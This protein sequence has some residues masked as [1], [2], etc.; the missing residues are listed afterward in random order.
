MSSLP[1]PTL[2]CRLSI[3][4]LFTAI[5]SSTVAAHAADHNE[6]INSIKMKLVLVKAGEFNMG[7]SESDDA[8]NKAFPATVKETF[9][10]ERPRHKVRITKDFYMGAS[11]V[12]L[13]QFREFINDT[14]YKTEAEKDDKGGWG[15]DP[16]D[17][18]DPFDQSPDYTCAV[19]ASTRETSIPW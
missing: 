19:G 17:K 16:D 2:A 3:A 1:M 9:D 5:A 12:T 18:D 13:E 8:L 6:K 14:N 4:A 7:N 15:F 10:E 11:N